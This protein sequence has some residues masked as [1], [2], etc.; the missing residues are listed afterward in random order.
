MF[1]TPFALSFGPR[2]A[3]GVGRFLRIKRLF[4]LTPA[5][6]TENL[7]KALREHVIIGGYGFAGRELAEALNKCRIPN[8][9]VDLNVENVRNASPGSSHAYFGDI[10]NYNVLKQLGIDDAREFVVLI[11]DPGAT[12]QAVR[13]ARRIAPDLHI[14]VRTYYLL[15]IEPL[16]KAG[17]DEVI[18]A[19]REAAVKV[20]SHIL[21][22]HRADPERIK[23]SCSEIRSRSE[24]ENV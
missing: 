4:E 17:A 19:E 18:P 2:L 1:L 22:R 6:D 16:L 23:A 13:I 12:E 21:G 7:P 5:D 11:N 15:D 10:T 20:T 14:V 8:V 3:S 24:E 9:I